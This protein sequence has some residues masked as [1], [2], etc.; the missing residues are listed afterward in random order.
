MKCPEIP[1][2]EDA[3]LQALS[4]YG[5]GSERALPSLDPVVQIAARMFGMPVA[6]VNMIGSDHVFLAA[7]TGIPEDVDKARDVS[8]CAHAIN[9]DDVMVVAD[10]AL[11]DRFHDNPLVTGSAGVRFYAGVPLRSPSGHPLGA[12][13]IIDGKPHHDFSEDDRQRLREL[14]TMAADRLEL[15]RIEVSAET[16]RRPFDAYAKDSPTA[17]VWFDEDCRIVSWNS[18]AAALHGHEAGGGNGQPPG[19]MFDALLADDSAAV[20]RDLVRR[21]I[22]AGSVEDLVMPDTLHARRRDGSRFLLGLSLFCWRENGR[23]TFNAH[24]QDLTARRHE[25]DSLRRLAHTD[26]LTG[27]A[28]RNQF[29]RQVEATLTHPRAATVVMLD[30]D[31]FKDINDTLGHGVGD[32]LLREAARR[33]QALAGPDATVARLGGDEFGILVPDVDAREPAMALASEAVAALSEP[34]TAEGQQVHLAASCGVAVAPLQAQ[35]ALE[36]IGDADLALARAKSVGRGQA[37]LFVPALRMEATSRRL[38][39]ME[40]HRAVTDG[41]FVLFYQPQVRLCDGALVG[42]EALIRWRHPRRGLLAPAAFLPALEGGPLAASVGAWV[43]DEACAQAARWRHAGARSFRMGVNLFSAQF[44]VGDL[45]REVLQALD[46]HGLT[47]DALELEITE[48]IALDHDDVVLGMLRRLHDEGVS[49]A[50]DDFGTGYAS[51]AVLKR[52]PLNRLKIDR[53][54]VHGMLESERDASVVRAVLD[55]ARAFNVHAI[56]EGVET[57]AQRDA[58]A[59]DCAEGQGYLFSPPIPAPDFARAYDIGWGADLARCA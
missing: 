39:G 13:C 36:L 17:V 42:A 1:A 8:F 37:Y 10:A 25:E 16:T 43:L 21:A 41:E 57:C 7:Q 11:D 38:H 40:L 26:L 27:L 51:L 9:Q 33:L 54:F 28:N 23:L 49:I 14:A 6:A 56:A 58:L 48:N 15:R 29:Y 24:L 45:A 12:L 46:R 55:M 31:N 32:E 18:A 5:L 44:H 2:A 50:F 34:V 59:A 19:L 35:E 22:T 53:S 52:Y 47:P 4:E 20:L 30:L 3:R